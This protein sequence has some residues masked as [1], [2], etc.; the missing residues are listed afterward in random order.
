MKKLLYAIIVVFALGVALPF[1][2]SC[3]DTESYADLVKDERHY[4]ADWVDYKGIEVYGK[5]DEEQIEDITD[6]IIE[7]S[8]SPSNYIE[9]GKW[10]QI[11]EGDFKRLYFKINSWGNDYPDMKSAK[12]FYEGDNALVR[13]EDLYCLSTFDYDSLENNSPADNLDPNSFEIVYNWSPSYYA[14][15]Y[16]SYYYSTGSSYECTSGGLA[17]PVRFLWQGGE[18]SLIIPFSLVSSTYSSYYYTLYYGTVRYTRPN[19]LPE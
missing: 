8:I 11:T 17:F 18:A 9:L 6:A 15:T 13:Y 4:I 2:T 12:K 19:Y 1:I 7:D 16:Y 14:S 5:F 3:D 10:Y